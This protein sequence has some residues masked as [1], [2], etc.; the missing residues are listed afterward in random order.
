[1]SDFWVK[2]NDK[3]IGLYSAV[4]VPDTGTSGSIQLSIPETEYVPGILPKK[5]G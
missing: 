3:Q 4:P 2:H 1:M 5:L